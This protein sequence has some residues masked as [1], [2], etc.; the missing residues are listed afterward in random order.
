M[1]VLAA[2]HLIL[3]ESSLMMKISWH[4]YRKSKIAETCHKRKGTLFNTSLKS[5]RK[6]KNC[7]LSAA[8]VFNIKCTDLFSKKSCFCSLKCSGTSLWTAFP[9]A[10]GS[11]RLC[12]STLQAGGFIPAILC[13][14]PLAAVFSPPWSAQLLV[15]PCGEPYWGTELVK[16]T[17]EKGE[18]VSFYPFWLPY[19]ILWAAAQMLIYGITNKKGWCSAGGW[20]C[21]ADASWAATQWGFCF[22][23]SNV[24]TPARNDTKCIRGNTRYL[25][26]PSK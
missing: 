8:T 9:L 22:V 24:S 15:Q 16:L 13:L 12:C 6:L 2:E 20:Q 18:V 19:M 7:V 14:Q 26:L 23:Y 3:G 4:F 11:A 25:K 5:R 1:T 21:L 10:H 17:Q